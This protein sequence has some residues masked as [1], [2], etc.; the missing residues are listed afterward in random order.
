MTIGTRIEMARKGIA[1]DRASGW[2]EY[3]YRIG[4][5]RPGVFIISIILLAIW[6]N[7]LLYFKV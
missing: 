5:E 6:V 4:K 1:Y 2:M 7:A 3:G